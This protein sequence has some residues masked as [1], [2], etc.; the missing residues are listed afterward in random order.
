MAVH[1]EPV[2][3]IPYKFYDLEGEKLR[4]IQEEVMARREEKSRA[5]SQNSTSD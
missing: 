2:T 5:A 4:T 3:L 1:S